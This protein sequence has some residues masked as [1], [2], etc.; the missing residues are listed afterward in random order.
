MSKGS[1]VRPRQVSDEQYAQRWDL[2]FARDNPEDDDEKGFELDKMLFAAE[3]ED[4][5]LNLA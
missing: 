1:V 3:E 2:I 4:E 5:D